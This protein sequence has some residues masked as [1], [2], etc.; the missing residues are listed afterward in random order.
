MCFV[1][2]IRVSVHPFALPSGFEA[3]RD[4][5]ICNIGWFFEGSCYNRVGVGV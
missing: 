5:K 2:S 4:Y 3:K 1:G